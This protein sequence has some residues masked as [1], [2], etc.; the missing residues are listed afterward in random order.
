[1]IVLGIGLIVLGVV[2]WPVV[3]SWIYGI[4][5][6]IVGLFIL[7]NKGEDVIEGIKSGRKNK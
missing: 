2:V 7:L 5:V 4:P 1:M 6:L 3:I